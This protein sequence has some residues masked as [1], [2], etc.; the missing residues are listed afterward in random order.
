MTL[1]DRLSKLDGPD[2]ETDVLVEVALFRPDKFYKSARANAAGTKVVFTRTDDM[3]ETF[4]ARDH[5]K[6]PERRAKS[7]ALLRAKESEQ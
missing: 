7:I 6:T 2:N 5:T 4:W 1:I 3:C